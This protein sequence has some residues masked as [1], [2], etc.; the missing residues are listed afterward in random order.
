MSFLIKEAECLVKRDKISAYPV[1]GKI[2]VK[3]E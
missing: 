2:V 3:V 1:A